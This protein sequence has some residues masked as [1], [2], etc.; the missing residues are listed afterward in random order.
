MGARVVNLVVGFWLFVSA[1]LW[2]HSRAERLNAWII[3]VVAV[4]AALAGLSGRR[5]GR[6]VNVAA[7]GWL[8]VSSLVP[9]ISRLT[10][11]NHMLVGLL[12]AMFG[13]APSL[14]ALRERRPVSP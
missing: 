9:T 2:Q 5:W 12:L 4:S 3:G 13:V 6:F 10:F 14:A 7:G 1:F 8:I 11:W